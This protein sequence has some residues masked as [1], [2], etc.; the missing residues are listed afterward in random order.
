MRGL[1]RD[2]IDFRFV[3]AGSVVAAC[4]FLTRQQGILVPAAVGMALLFTRRLWFDRAT[5][6]LTLAVAAIPAMTL[7]AY[8]V[9][10]AVV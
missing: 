3:I 4:A 2:A 7:V 1:R 5:V 6:K 10:A 9:L 8:F